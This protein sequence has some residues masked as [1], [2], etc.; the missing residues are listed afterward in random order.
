VYVGRYGSPEAHQR[1]LELMVEHGYLPA[2]AAGPVA[3]AEKP[4]ELQPAVAPVAD[5]PGGDADVPAGLT[6]GELCRMY[7]VHLEE[8]RPVGR[9]CSRWNRALAA[10][11]AMRPLATMPAAK[12]GTRAFLDVRQRLIATPRRVQEKKSK[13]PGKRRRRKLEEQKPPAPPVLLSRRWINDVMQAV[14]LMFDWAVLHELVP[15]DRAGAL[16][17]VKALKA[18]ESKAR[19]TPRRKPV[20]PSVVRATLPHLTA[21]VADLVLF[22]RWTG[23]RPGEAMGMRWGRILDRDKPVWR[24]APARHKTAHLG[25]QRHVPI[26]RK[27]RAILEAR[28]S[29]RDPRDYVFKPERSLR[30]VEPADGVLPMRL[31]KAS[32]QVG[33]RFTKGA[34]R[35]AIRRAVARANKVRKKS[36]EPPLPHWV[37]YQLRYLRLREIRKSHGLEASQATAGHSDSVMTNHYAPANWDMAAR[38]ARATG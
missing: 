12:F 24:F 21:E 3:V 17:V 37:P 36:G 25:K 27:A 6:L 5:L 33:E 30:R 4:A 7:L 20:K 29:S 23:C 2:S 38:A 28:E 34:L 9:A 32:P 14:R 1:Y 35:L 31:A 22:I 11:R 10:V 13:P 8:S 15:D 19:E 18:G 16:A 26:G